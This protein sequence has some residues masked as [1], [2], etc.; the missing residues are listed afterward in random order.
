MEK[1]SAASTAVSATFSR[2]SPPMPSNSLL[3]VTYILLR[4]PSVLAFSTS[5]SSFTAASAL[6]AHSGLQ[7][8]ISKTWRLALSSA[9]LSVTSLSLKSGSAAE[10]AS[11]TAARTSGYLPLRESSTSMRIVWVSKSTEACDIPETSETAFSTFSAQ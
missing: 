1:P 7:A 9:T 5:S 4:A 10:A 2:T 8:P 3:K 11:L 6:S